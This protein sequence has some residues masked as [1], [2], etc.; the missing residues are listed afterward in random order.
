[1]R[2][3]L[4]KLTQIK[5]GVG[6]FVE[7]AFLTG[8]G[9]NYT[10]ISDAFGN[11]SYVK[12]NFVA[13]T[14]PG[15]SDDG[16]QGYR[17]GSKWIN[18]STTEIYVC[19]SAVTGN[20]VWEQS[21]LTLDDLGSMATQ[22][23]DTVAITGGTIDGTTI[24]STTPAAAAFTQIAIPDIADTTLSGAPK[25]FVIYDDSGTPYYIKAYPTKA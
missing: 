8:A 20:A 17:V 6:S 16:T 19:I 11:L 12:N 18:T 3:K 22:N 13:I 4:L 25:V 21:T 5:N 14:N 15:T 10:L 23:A 7:L 2:A 24:G 1:M 9:A